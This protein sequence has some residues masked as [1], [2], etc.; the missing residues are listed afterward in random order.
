MLS[1]TLMGLHGH[2]GGF[3]KD[4]LEIKQLVPQCAQCGKK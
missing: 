3:T 2:N 4:M 1:V